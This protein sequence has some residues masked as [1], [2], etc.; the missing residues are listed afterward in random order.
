MEHSQHD[1]A[2]DDPIICYSCETELPEGRRHCPGCGRSQLRTCYCGE[3]IPV[4]LMTCP[5]CEEAF[6]VELSGP[7]E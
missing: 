7:G 1:T 3:D 4:T 2:A 6:E 5:H